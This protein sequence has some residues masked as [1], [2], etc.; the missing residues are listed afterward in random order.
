MG[1]FSTI[2]AWN[3]SVGPPFCCCF[4]P[5]QEIKSLRSCSSICHCENLT[6][7]C[8]ARGRDL[9]FILNESVGLVADC[10]DV[11]DIASKL[12]VIIRQVASG[13]TSQDESAYDAVLKRYSVDTST[14]FLLEAFSRAIAAGLKDRIYYRCCYE[15]NRQYVLAPR[16]TTSMFGHTL[17]LPENLFSRTSF[18]VKQVS[19]WLVK[20]PRLSAG[21]TICLSSI[22]WYGCSEVRDGIFHDFSQFLSLFPGLS[23]DFLRKGFYYWTLAHCSIQVKISFGTLVAH[24]QTEV[25]E[26]VYIGPYCLI[27]TAVIWR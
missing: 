16:L 7:S 10:N 5:G 22:D 2:G 24:P 12:S 21:G 27:G 9:S 1:R 14:G 3:I 11:D 15:E 26:G 13:N 8:S 6:G 4:N 17:L 23:G 18:H 20:W 25:H 19:K